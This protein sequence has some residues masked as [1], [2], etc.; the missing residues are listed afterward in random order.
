MAYLEKLQIIVA[1]DTLQVVKKWLTL[2]EEAK[3]GFI[4]AA[5]EYAKYE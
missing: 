5:T 1:Y 4:Q 2:N 3:D